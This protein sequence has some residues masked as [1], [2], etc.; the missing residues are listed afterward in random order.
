VFHLNTIDITVMAVYFGILLSFGFILRKLAAGS[1][2]DYFLGGKRLPWWMLGI[3][4]MGQFLDITG[5]VLIT[6]FLFMLGPRG[7][8]IEFRGGACLA[9]AVMLL[10]IGK[11]H[12]RSN[13]MTGAQWQ[14]YRFGS[15]PDGQWARVLAAVSFMF[16]VIG[17]FAYMVEGVGSFLSTFLPYPPI[18]CALIMLGLA[19]IY[20]ML[21]GFYGVVLTDL[22]QAGVILAAVVIIT[23]MAFA[24][25]G[26]YDEGTLTGLAAQVTGNQDWGLTSPRWTTPMPEGYKQYHWLGALMTLYLI[27]QLMFGMGYIQDPKFFGAR[28]ER[29]CGK[30]TFLWTCLMTFR[31][32]LMMSF[33][34]LGIFL[35]HEKFPDQSVLRESAQIIRTHQSTPEEWEQFF[36]NEL[37]KK[38]GEQPEQLVSDLQGE[39]GEKWDE[40]LTAADQAMVLRLVPTISKYKSPLDKSDWAAL[41]S[42]IWSNP[43]GHDAEMIAQLKETLGDEWRTKVRM[44][45]FEGNVDPESILPSV[46]LFRIPEGLRGLFMIA[47]IAASMSTFDL[48]LNMVTALF[49]KDLYQKFIRPRA[50][51]REL[52]FVSYGFC[53]FVVVCAF[54]L[55]LQAENIN[56]I[57]GW[58]IMGLGASMGIPLILRLYWWR[59]NGYGFA[60]G[61]SVSL[62]AA[63]VQRIVYPEMPEM[64][65]FLY[66]SFISLVAT[67]VGT[68]VTQPTDR[69]VLENFYRTTR[70]FGF[71]GPLRNT[72]SP[73]KLEATDKEN[74]N[75][76]IALPFTLLWQVTMLLMPMQIIIQEYRD[77]AFTFPI[78]LISLFMLYKYWYK[79]LPPERDG[80]EEPGIPND[81]PPD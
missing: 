28:N 19:T 48:G 47:L 78:F 55:S 27:R 29:E 24:A 41:R 34:V 22:F 80:V 5:T 73:E 44:L 30:L 18:V 2:E 32:P 68:L 26:N 46:I 54:L 49:T 25:I 70:P 60:I 59:A 12:R 33:A 77:F 43:E 11:W 81:A 38:P 36:R 75:D 42:S 16:L 14:I 51:N 37:A 64:W 1:L 45:S 62:L 4:G 61:M 31:W 9:L 13:C 57:W 71:W 7:L 17:G 40:Q 65:Q 76:L 10:W 74:R 56:E 67:I 21:S 20:T 50:K 3:A 58:I 69:K 53:I 52:V 79:N 23:V 35:V 8:Y 15:G 63:V 39:L 6:S 72:L 66:V